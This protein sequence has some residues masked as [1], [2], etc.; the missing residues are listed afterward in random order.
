MV[1]CGLLL[2]DV[3]CLVIL[4]VHQSN[5][6]FQ[7]PNVSVD[8]HGEMEELFFIQFLVMGTK[9][10]ILPLLKTLQLYINT[11]FHQKLALAW[12]NSYNYIV[13]MFVNYLIVW[14]YFFQVQFKKVGTE[15]IIIIIIAAATLS[16]E[17][18][19][20]FKNNLILFLVYIPI[21]YNIRVYR[22]VPVYYSRCYS[23]D[24]CQS[25]IILFF[26]TFQSYSYLILLVQIKM[27]NV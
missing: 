21:I 19:H 7:L 17:I 10:H 11:Q 16:L 14:I 24:R 6:S 13:S 8:F 2:Y 9:Y 15:T 18:D 3:A 25:K 27:S 12:V 4:Q 1:K 22:E 23:S 5:N 26:M 20:N